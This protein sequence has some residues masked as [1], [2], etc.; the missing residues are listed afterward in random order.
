MYMIVRGTFELSIRRG[1]E[2]CVPSKHARDKDL[3]LGQTATTRKTV[4]PQGEF[5]TT[6]FNVKRQ[7]GAR[8]LAPGERK[9]R[10]PRF[11]EFAL[12]NPWVH[13]A[14][15]VANKSF[16]ISKFKFKISESSNLRT[17]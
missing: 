11:A 2:N 16:E 17:C 15:W 3:E 10:L 9:K 4:L 8:S 13:K 14:S 1:R 7:G 6:L 12:F 5:H